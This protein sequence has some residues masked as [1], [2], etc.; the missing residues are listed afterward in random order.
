MD[1]F[2]FFFFFFFSSPIH[3]STQ[4]I[5]LSKANNFRFLKDDAHLVLQIIRTLTSKQSEL[6]LHKCCSEG[7]VSYFIMLADNIRGGCWWYSSRGWTFPPILC[8]ILLLCNRWQQR[9]SL[10][11]WCLTWKHRWS[12]GVELNSSMWKK[13]HPLTLIDICWTFMETKQW[14]WAQWGGGWCFSA[15]VTAMWN[16]SPV[17]DSHALSHCC[18]STKWRALKSA[19]LHYDQGTVYRAEYQLQYVGKDGS[20]AGISQCLHHVGPTNALPGTERTP[21]TSLSGPVEPV[22]G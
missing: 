21:Y 9:G 12:K 15:A 11:E 14:V 17:P 13:K 20:N 3:C 8:Y 18:H 7:N 5:V 22:W 16:T 4:E 19:Y 10:T 2:F 1:F 6:L